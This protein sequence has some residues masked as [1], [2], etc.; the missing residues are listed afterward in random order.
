MSLWVRLSTT[1]SPVD[2]VNGLGVW[3]R[4]GEASSRCLLDHASA[5]LH[6]PHLRVAVVLQ[7]VLV[8]SGQLHLGQ[9]QNPKAWLSSTS[10]GPPAVQGSSGALREESGCLLLWRVP[11]AK[12]SPPQHPSHTACPRRGAGRGASCAIS[13]G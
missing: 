10:P 3:W 7:N 1:D 8:T 11:L 12:P 13:A 5:A 2:L 9:T 6:H 4:D